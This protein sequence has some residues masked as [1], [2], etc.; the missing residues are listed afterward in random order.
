MEASRPSAETLVESY[1]LPL[2]IYQPWGQGGVLLI[3][4]SEFL[5]G[6]N[7]EAETT[8]REGNILFLRQVLEDYLG[9][10]DPARA[11]GIP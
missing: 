11:G 6:G 8:Y 10:G 5:L 1:G 4:D 7:L 3:G 9:L 2:V